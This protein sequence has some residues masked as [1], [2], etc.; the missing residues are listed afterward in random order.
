MGRRRQESK[1]HDGVNWSQIQPLLELTPSDT[2][3]ILNCCYAGNAALS[4]MQS[5]TEI[6]PASDRDTR[7]EALERSFLKVLVEALGKLGKSKFSVDDLKDELDKYNTFQGGKRINHPFHKRF[8]ASG[9]PS[10][11]LQPLPTSAN[12]SRSTTDS[13]QD[14]HSASKSSFF[15]EISLQAPEKALEPGWDSFFMKPDPSL[16]RRLHFYTAKT[17]PER[18]KS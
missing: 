9:H 8:P 4:D 6:L 2:L 5:T 13:V 17:L 3:V 12:L 1:R 16:V 11:Q 15:V 7:A 10:I 18:P 14:R